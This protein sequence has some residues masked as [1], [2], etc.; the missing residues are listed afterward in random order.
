M[1]SNW[2]YY[3]LMLLTVEKIVQHIVV[4]LAFYFNWTDIASTVVVSP[5]VLMVLGA[6]V[7]MLFIISLWGLL[8]KRGWSINLLIGLALLTWWA[9]L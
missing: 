4:T 3:G 7:A 6:L 2:V 1:R 5:I 9:S 8:Q